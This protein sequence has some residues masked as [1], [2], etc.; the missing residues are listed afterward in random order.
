MVCSAINHFLITIN[1]KTMN[2][3]IILA[4]AIFSTASYAVSAQTGRPAATNRQRIKQ[5]VNNGELNRA[6]AARLKAQ[7]AKLAKEK[8]D[9]REDGVV[10]KE[11]RKDIRQDQ[12]K[13]SKRIYRQK[14][15]GQ[16]RH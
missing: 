12:K 13:L 1:F 8:K 3:K 7:N 11:E 15:D 5:G 9:A 10:T 16:V 14:H 2:L 6:E 4:I